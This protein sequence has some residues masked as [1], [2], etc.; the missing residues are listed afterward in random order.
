MVTRVSQ[1]DLIDGLLRTRGTVALVGGIDTGKTAFGLALAQAARNEGIN[2]AYVDS[3]IGQS[4]VGPPSCVGLKLCAALDTVDRR[5]VADADE[6]AFVG[7]FVPEHN[8]PALLAG[9]ARLVAHAREAGCEMVVVDTCGFISGPDAEAL[10]YHKLDLIGPTEVVGFQRGEELDPI[11]SIAGRFFSVEVACVQVPNEQV[12]RSAEER[13]SERE[14]RFAGYFSEPL[15]RWRVKPT[16]FMPTLTPQEDLSRLD[17][18]LVGLEDGRGRCHG[19]GLL[20]HQAEGNILRMVSSVSSG[21]KGLR[22]GSV[23]MT[24]EGK[25]VGRYAAQQFFGV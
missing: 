13:L 6:L 9:T 10:K 7:S 1:Q 23:R 5:S 21:A 8:I 25:T 22:L 24:T 17:G 2:V 16:V 12:C 15:Y 19:I 20:E 18:L 14:A 11:L 3:D 4:T